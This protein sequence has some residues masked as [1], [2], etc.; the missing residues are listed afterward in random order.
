MQPRDPKPGFVAEAQNDLVLSFLAVRR[1]LGLLGLFLPLSL[2]ATAILTD[3]PMRPSISEFY[4]GQGREF[5]VGTLCAI[6]VFLWSYVG[7]PPAHRGEA[8]TDKQVS[9]IAAVAVICVALFPTGDNLAPPGQ[10]MQDCS[11]FQCLV[12][13]NISRR[14]HYLA[15]GIFFSSLALFCLVLFR[16]DG[17]QGQ[18]AEKAARNRIYA[19]CGWT[20]VACVLALGVYGVVYAMQ[21]SVGKTRLDRS[22]L[23]FILE[24]IGIF[25][26]AISWLTKG[27][28][29]QPLEALMTKTS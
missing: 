28:A 8:P 29:L 27:K 7:Y 12:G 13:E 4:H 15:A 22:Y 6:G 20:I 2:L 3:E 10:V 17:G 23:V 19:L 18:D 14:L 16:R 1:M 26:F 24:S 5:F 21:D 25:A 9:R 11:V